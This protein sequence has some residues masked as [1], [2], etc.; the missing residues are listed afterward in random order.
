MSYFKK[1][2]SLYII[3][4]LALTPVLIWAFLEPLSLRFFDLNSTMTSLGQISGLIGL[5]LFSINLIISSRLK[6]IDKAFWGIDKAYLFHEW[7]GAIAFSLILFHPLFLVVKYLTISLVNAALFFIPGQNLANT[8]G[9][10]ALLLFVVLIG[11]TFYIKIKY[12]Y[13]KLSHKFMVLVFIIGLFHVILVSSDTSRSPLLLGYL[14][15]LGGLGF[16]GGAYRTFFHKY[17]NQNLEYVIKSIT[18]LNGQ[19]T[20]IIAEP[21]RKALQ[22][23][24]GQFVYVRFNNSQIGDEIHPFSIASANNKKDL[25][26]VIKSLGDFTKQVKDVEPGTVIFLDGPLGYFSQQNYSNKK[27]LWIAGGI[28]IT[29]FLSMAGDLKNHTDHEVDLYYCAKNRAE[30]VLV[31]ELSKI[32]A[33]NPN[34]RIFFWLSEEQGRITGHKILERTNDLARREVFICGPRIFSE[35]LTSQLRQLSVSARKIH[36]EKFNL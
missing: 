2:L 1:N 17:F 21:I 15:V 28:G 5:A 22:F 25:R 18:H 11:I 26:L 35:T 32:S 16:L 3:L 4:I 24:P 6:I 36:S 7:I 33:E 27:Q 34:F 19:I 13:W 29:P 14:L 30:L 23:T 20:Q 9:I 8:F 12:Q 10:V 31:D